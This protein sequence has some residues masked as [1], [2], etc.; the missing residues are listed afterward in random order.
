M[1]LIKR[2]W[3]DTLENRNAYGFEPIGIVSTKKE[4]ERINTMCQ[5]PK[6]DYPWPLAYATEFEGSTVPK[7]QIEKMT[8]LNNMTMKQLIKV[9]K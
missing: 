6:S 8:N 1:Y 9:K 5:I 7:F 2:L 3:I 4:A